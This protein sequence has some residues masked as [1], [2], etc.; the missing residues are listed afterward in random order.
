M[1]GALKA[2]MRISPS[3]I[4]NR[5]TKNPVSESER[6]PKYKLHDV[7]LCDLLKNIAADRKLPMNPKRQMTGLEYF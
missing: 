5:D 1:P 6:A 3:Q 4:Q 7:F 2:F